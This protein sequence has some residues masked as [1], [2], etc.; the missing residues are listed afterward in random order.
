MRASR[1]LWVMLDGIGHAPPGPHNP[2]DAR[3]QPA[4]GALG[5]AGPLEVSEPERRLAS[6]DATLGVPGLPQSA[7]GQTTL[8][9]GANAARHLGHHHG[10]WPGPT[11]RPLLARSLPV[12]LARAGG[13]LRLANSYPQRYLESVAT[14]RV[15]L[16][17]IA[18]SLTLAGTALGERG[19]PADLGGD[20]V[21]PER[22]D[23]W[24][25]EMLASPA[26]LTVLDAWWSDHLGHRGTPES[27]R[28][29][30]A[31]LDRLLAATV[32]RR[33]ASTL[34]IVTA[35]HG[36]LERADVR[37]HSRNPVPL[38]ALGPGAGAF[39]PVTDLSGV[40]PAL[41]ATMGWDATATAV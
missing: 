16:N 3:A 40:A 33:P 20:A 1:V 11:L 34:V 21:E 26:D 41:A 29:Y 2:L 8:L 24:A 18:S 31:R 30:L 12:R 15:R 35:D 37:T 27:A 5:I 9:S 28:A 22:L 7:T 17:A 32:E 14:G 10:P 6:V 19:V 4:L 23:G 13:T 39:A 25:E 36:N 38:V